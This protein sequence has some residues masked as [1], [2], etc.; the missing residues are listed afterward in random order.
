MKNV[1]LTPLNLHTEILDHLTHLGTAHT[2]L[3]QLDE[4]DTANTACEILYEHDGLALRYYDASPFTNAAKKAPIFICYA[5]VNRWYMLDLDPDRSFVKHLLAEGHDLY[6]LDWGYPDITDQFL[7]LSDYIDDRLATCIEQACN[8]AD[9]SKINLLGVCQGGVLALC[10][11]ALYPERIN[12]LIL[13]VTPVDFHTPDN[14]L[15][16][17]THQIDAVKLSNTFG[18]IPGHF[19][20][21][22]FAHLTPLKQSI[23][24]Q[25]HL[26]SACQNT[27][28]AKRFLRME[29]WI[30]D[31]PD[32][33]A[34]AFLEF[35]NLC[36]KDNALMNNRMKIGTQAINLKALKAQV[37]NVFGQHDHL[38]PPA[39]S[40][41]LKGLLPANIDYSEYEVE[42]GHIGVFVSAKSLKTV[43]AHISKWL[44]SDE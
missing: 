28:S 38:V 20:S 40:K 16:A 13:C 29:K 21:Q 9:I 7:D 14:A 25:L 5:L 1:S 31:C 11:S 36:F 39:S 4:I 33:A 10:F 30:N 18:N 23:D 37:L 12:R 3:Q 41:A 19:L 17:L 43:P 35:Q 34:A 6:V 24:K 2:T 32:Q 27:T 26:I 8:H 15:R 22:T 42:A 44:C